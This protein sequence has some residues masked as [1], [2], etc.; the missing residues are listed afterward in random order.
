MGVH[1][2]RAVV[3]FLSEQGDAIKGCPVTVL[4]M[5]FKENVPDIRN[6]R[7]I[8]VVRE[9]AGGGASRVRRGGWPLVESLPKG[10]GAG[11]APDF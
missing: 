4:G 6:S 3:R 7:V 2:A 9:R 8:D 5:T 1:A 10:G 11:P